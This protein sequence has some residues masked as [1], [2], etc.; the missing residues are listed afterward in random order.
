MK[1]EIKQMK[2]SDMGREL[3]GKLSALLVN[4]W[5]KLYPTE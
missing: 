2:H 1:F 5:T 4:A 3:S